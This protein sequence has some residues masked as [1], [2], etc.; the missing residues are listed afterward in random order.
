[1]ADLRWMRVIGDSIFA[2][3]A[4]AFVYAVVRL[5]TQRS[6]PTTATLDSVLPAADRTRN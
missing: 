4:V 3:G 6:R 1:M 2:A 5:T